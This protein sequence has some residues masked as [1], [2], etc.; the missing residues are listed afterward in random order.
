MPRLVASTASSRIVSATGRLSRRAACGRLDHRRAT[1]PARP[2][3]GWPMVGQI[4][5]CFDFSHG[6]RRRDH[7]GDLVE[8]NAAQYRAEVGRVRRRHRQPSARATSSRSATRPEPA[9]RPE[10]HQARRSGHGYPSPPPPR[11]RRPSCSG[12]GSTPGTPN[13]GMRRPSTVV[14]A[15]ADQTFASGLSSGN[16]RALRRT[17]AA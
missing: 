9:S 14:P 7:H 11:S 15:S 1:Y 5:R 10:S 8:R 12:I 6:T 17:V 13:G 2:D 16:R 3:H 4:L